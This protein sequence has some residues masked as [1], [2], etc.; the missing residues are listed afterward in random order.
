MVRTQ[1]AQQVHSKLWQLRYVRICPHT[2]VTCCMQKSEFTHLL[3]VNSLLPFTHG[4]VQPGT[5]IITLYAT[6]GGWSAYA[7]STV[8]Y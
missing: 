1:S 8:A 4:C 3:V 7:F 6:G 5:I 2:Q